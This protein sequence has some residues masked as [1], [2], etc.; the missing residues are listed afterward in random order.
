MSGVAD[1]T[2]QVISFAN[3]T[4]NGFNSYATRINLTSSPNFFFWIMFGLIKN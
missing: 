2:T 4:N 3:I 1:G